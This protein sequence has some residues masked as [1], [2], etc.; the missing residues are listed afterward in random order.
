N[1]TTGYHLR[2]PK[3]NSTHCPGWVDHYTYYRGLGK[4]VYAV[5]DQQEPAQRQAITES[6]DFPY[7]APETGFEN[8]VLNGTDVAVLRE[9]A[10]DLVASESWPS[11]LRERVP[12]DQ[13]TVDE[14]KAI[15]SVLLKRWKG[16]G[17]AAALLCTA[18]NQSQLPPFIVDTLAKICATVIRPK[19][20]APDLLDDVLDLI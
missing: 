20:A 2:W 16:D 12:T 4:T 1:S 14:L 8:V 15:L 17:A 11:D 3:K 7:E 18:T 5:F 19:P 9:Y 10:A 6:V 13:T